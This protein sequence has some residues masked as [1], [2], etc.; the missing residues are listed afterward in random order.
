[1]CLLEFSSM[2]VF[3]AELTRVYFKATIYCFP[4]ISGLEY[5]P[6]K[7][8]CKYAIGQILRNPTLTVVMW[9]KLL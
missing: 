1:M 2:L 5:E 9:K 7:Y 4:V 8:K 6:V 3:L